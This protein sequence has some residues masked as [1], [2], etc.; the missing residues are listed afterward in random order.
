MSSLWKETV[1]LPHFESLKGDLKV[2]ILIIGGGLAGVLCAYKLQKLSVDYALVEAE[3][4]CNK[5][6]ANTTAKITSQHG[7][8][9]NKLIKKIGAERAGRYYA[10]NQKALE[11][12]RKIC[13]D[14]DCEFENKNS[15][16]Y[17][18]KQSAELENE[19]A[20]IEKLNINGSFCKEVLLPF[21]I[22]G[23][24]KFSNQA[25]FNPL[26]FAAHIAKN[27][28]IFEHTK[29][30]AFNGKNIEY[31]AGKIIAQKVIVATHFPIF[32]KHGRYFLK[33]YQQR[34][35][36]TAYDNNKNLPDGMFLEA[37]NNGISIRKSGKYL[38]IGGGGHRTGKKGENWEA[39][40]GFAKKYYPEVEEKFRWAT[41][42]C[43]TLDGMPYIG[44]YAKGKTNLYVATGFNKWG[45]TT[46]MCAADI[47]V[48]LVLE[49]DNE[50]KDLFLPYRSILQPQLA[51][52]ALETTVNLLTPTAPRCP[53]LGCALKW[54]RAE[55]S[56]DCSCHGSRF[57][58]SGRLLDNPAT[59]DLKNIK[60]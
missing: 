38:L 27:L 58:E 47:L 57:S 31:N 32:N 45:M 29:V 37:C 42:D 22:W 52:N 5:V 53:H 56:W 3:T 10:A 51:V 13:K 1:E 4:I 2:D 12:Y 19:L 23:A 49:K 26:K 7:L 20:A 17:S 18:Q 6:T 46:A 44:E 50:Y 25:Q 35:Y 30:I 11:E 59:D 48:D 54:N 34:S 60:S 9:Y 41:Q 16:I 8:I 43:M 28:R 40:N 55:H 15:Y 39:I 36:V 21:D 14:I 33:M 24:L